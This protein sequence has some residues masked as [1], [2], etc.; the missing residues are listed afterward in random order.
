MAQEL[1]ASKRE[2]DFYLSQMAQAKKNEAIVSR[3]RQARRLPLCVPRRWLTRPITIR[4]CSGRL[5]SCCCPW[6]GESG[7]VLQLMYCTLYTA[8]R[9]SLSHKVAV[10]LQRGQDVT[11][12][13]TQKPRT[14][15]QRE[16]RKQNGTET[17]ASFAEMFS[18]L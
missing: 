6:E 8:R 3:K 1:A 7:A 15:T 11:L 5:L 12:G 17:A 14:F 4:Y 10:H 2:R 13:S 9:H 18:Q 16:E